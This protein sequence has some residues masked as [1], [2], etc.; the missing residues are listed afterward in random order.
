MDEAEKNRLRDILESAVTIAVVGASA[1]SAKAS[2]RI[3]Q[4][5]QEQGKDVI[6]V[7]PRGGSIFGRDAVTNLADV[8]QTIDV[9]D[10]FRPAAEAPAIAEQAVEVGAKVLWLQLGIVSPEAE[11]IASAAGLQVVMDR[12]IGA[13]YAKLGLGP[14]LERPDHDG[15]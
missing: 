7:N 1:D 14:A 13:T 11:A 15:P 3:P 5:L 6:P 12:C 9:V 4:Y 10:V 2:H 8:A